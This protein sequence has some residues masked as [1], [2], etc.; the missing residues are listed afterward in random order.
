[1]SR[2]RHH[3]SRRRSWAA[4]SDPITIR[5]GSRR[6]PNKHHDIRVTSHKDANRFAH[7]IGDQVR[8]QPR[9][10]LILSINGHQPWMGEVLSSCLEDCWDQISDVSRELQFAGTAKFPERASKRG[11]CAPWTFI[12]DQMN[13]PQVYS[14]SVGLEP[15]QAHGCE[16]PFIVQ[17]RMRVGVWFCERGACKLNRSV[18]VTL[19][20]TR[21]TP[22]ADHIIG[23]V[24]FKSLYSDSDFD[25]PRNDEEGICW[26]FSRLYWLFTNWRNVIRET[27][28]R[29]DEAEINC[30]GRYLPVKLRTRAMHIEVD[31]IYELQEY[32][33]FH[34]RSFRKLAK[35]KEGVPPEEQQDPLWSD[36]EDA[37]D[38]LEH[39][40]SSLNNLKERFLNLLDLEFNIQ[41]ADQTEDSS[42]LM[43]IATLFLPVSFLASVF[44]IQ[45]INW[46]PKWYLYSALPIF[47][48]SCI[49]V[50]IFPFTVRRYQKTRYGIEATRT[51][52][53][54][55]DFTMLGSDL[56][57]SV[58][59]PGSNRLGR[60][61]DQA[62]RES[63]GDEVGAP[64]ANARSQ[65]PARSSKE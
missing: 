26:T 30:S 62:Q 36:I 8:L 2:Q 21:S 28:A 63:V 18:S 42:F 54:Q 43:V 55:H 32:L 24:M 33:R 23:D 53:H 29:L 38:D 35:L 48:T 61:K 31:R 51:L 27:T 50:T 5:V 6:T 25:Q 22:I 17:Y 4:T 34:V 20:F 64:A 56:P 11:R 52:L 39:F 13:V 41:N 45:N 58:D 49:F 12:M 1:M 65:S 40:D 7:L 3:H 59:V 57:E 10:P 14:W 46:P 16:I 9:D 60:L 44:G 15:P 37:L 19:I 47:I